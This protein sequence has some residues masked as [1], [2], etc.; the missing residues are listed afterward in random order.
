[1]NYS[2]VVRTFI[3]AALLGLLLVGQT[4]SAVT[5]QS[6]N[7]AALV[8]SYENAQD[9]AVC[10]SFDEEEISGYELLRRS[11]LD[12]ESEPSGGFGEAICRIE[13]AWL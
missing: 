2:L 6:P 9:V 5:G 8:V 4:P 11:E 10:V 3:L 7:R 12:M 13:Y 1:M